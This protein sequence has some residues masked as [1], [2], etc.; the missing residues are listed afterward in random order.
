MPASNLSQLETRRRLAQWPRLLAEG[1]SIHRIAKSEGMS[2]SGV[3]MWLVRQGVDTGVGYRVQREE[4][5]LDRQHRAL[6]IRRY[7]DKDRCLC[8]CGRKSKAKGYARQCYINWWKRERRK[9][10]KCNRSR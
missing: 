6:K 1:W 9:V 3:R 2:F 5:A 4:Q 10:N 8:G 7:T